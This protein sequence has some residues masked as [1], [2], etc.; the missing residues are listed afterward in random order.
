MSDTLQSP[1]DKEAAAARFEAREMRFANVGSVLYRQRWLAI[2]TFAI[3]GAAVAAYTLTATPI[4]EAR[5]QLLLVDRGNLSGLESESSSIQ[6]PGYLETQ[7]RLLRSRPLIRSVITQLELWNAEGFATSGP[8]ATGAAGLVNRLQH[9]FDASASATPAGPES[10]AAGGPAETP[11][12]SIVID[13]T[14][15]HLTVTPVESTSII[16]VKFESP[17]PELAASVVNTLTSTFI[18][19]DSDAKARASMQAAARLDEQLAE[20]R[21]KVEA[22]ELALQTYRERENSLSLDAGQNIV[23]QRLNALNSAVTQAK[24]DLIAAEARYRQLAGSQSNPDALDSVAPIRTNGLVQQIKDRLTTLRRE[25]TQLSGS[26]GARHPDMIRLD[27]DI[28]MAE[29]E[30]TAEVARTVEAVRQEFLAAR[31]RERS[32]G[33]ASS[34]ACCCARSKATGRSTRTCSSA[35]TRR[36]FRAS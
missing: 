8:D 15:S 11:G 24:T 13:R 4:Y 22:S 17:K 31:S 34:T 9:S 27:A 19:Q 1:L 20:Q 21:R 28:A 18:A 10:A 33:R 36:R 7:R 26:L 6:Q 2:A 32:T 29:K 25:R 35:R 14:L 3:V 30:L 5:A 12:E 23:V 16:E